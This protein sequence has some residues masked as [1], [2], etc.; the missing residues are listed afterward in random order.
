MTQLFTNNAS[1]VLSGT[2]SQGGTTLVVATGT[3]DKFPT[4]TGDDFA[5]ITL[6]ET[7]V[8]GNESRI[9]VIKLT[10]R[11]ADTFTIVR[12]VEALT[13]QVGGFAYP[14]EV[15][16]QVNIELR[17][18]AMG[19]N[20]MLQ[21]SANLSD[22]A[23]SMVARGNLGLGN[24]NDTSDVDK[25]ISAAT[26]TAL[27]TKSP[28]S[29]NHTGTYEP[30]G[31][32]S[33]HVSAGDPHSQY[34]LESTIGAANGIASLGADG[35]VPAS[36]LP[37]SSSV[38]QTKS[39]NYTAVAGD[40]LWCDTTTAAF[41]ITLPATPAANDTVTVADYAG[42]FATNNLTIARN[43]SKIMGITEDMT[44]STNNVSIDLV[45]VDATQGWRIA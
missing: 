8:S 16:K 40:R 22:L 29:H 23:N 19:A 26:Q 24:V 38:W 5:L 25:P 34:A 4:P 20:G 11:T 42:T 21:K 12:D 15:G 27:D 1:T 44:I 43:G 18:T 32:V 31:T 10:A 39:A 9:E 3:G 37:A 2:L 45:Y 41:T 33:A 35:K 36:Q 28:T 7:D 13:G 6:Y 17:W 14:S 30:A